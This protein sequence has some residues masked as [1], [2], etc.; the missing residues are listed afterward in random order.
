MFVSNSRGFILSFF[1]ICFSVLFVGCGSKQGPQD[2]L[3]RSYVKSADSLAIIGARDSATKILQQQ[4]RAFQPG[5]PEMVAY[6]NY[7]SYWYRLTGP[8]AKLYADSALILFEN[9]DNIKRFPND[10]YQT[11]L[12]KAGAFIIQKQYANA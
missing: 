4:R 11:L 1:A 12:N 8:I 10:Y 6:Y 5:D 2:S 7:M 9:K 3:I